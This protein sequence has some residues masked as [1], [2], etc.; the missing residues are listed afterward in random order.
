MKKLKTITALFVLLV[1]SG[2][3]AQNTDDQKIIDDAM[4]AKARLL[5]KDAGLEKFFDNSE[6]YAIFPNVGEGGFILGAASGNGVVYENGTAVGMTNLKKVD[7]GFQIGGQALAEV[8]FFETEA[9]LNEFKT[10]EYTVSGEVSATALK[11]GVSEN[12]NYSDGVIVVVMPKEGLMADVSV[13]GQR[14]GYTP[15]EQIEQ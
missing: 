13:G 4:E 15:M 5:E 8:I 3:Y 7:I 14:F 12:L 11:E 10:G 1:T 2:I 9:A 6:G